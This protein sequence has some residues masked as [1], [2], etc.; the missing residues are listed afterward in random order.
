MAKKVPKNPDRVYLSKCVG[1][2][3]AYERLGK[4]EEARQWANCLVRHLHKMDLL[5][6]PN[7]PIDTPA[8]LA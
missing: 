6:P 4:K 5:P 2:L 8:K 7:G 1:S 3:M